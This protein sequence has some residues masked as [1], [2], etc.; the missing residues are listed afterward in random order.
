VS[1]IPTG[2]FARAYGREMDRRRGALR[3]AYLAATKEVYV[4]E[5]RSL[6]RR[7]VLQMD[8]AR[9]EYLALRETPGGGIPGAH[10][11]AR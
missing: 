8:A 1:L 2:F 5:L 7:I 3:L 6:R 11:E 9:L 4:Q 10:G